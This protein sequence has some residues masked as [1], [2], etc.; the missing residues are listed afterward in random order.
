G[1]DRADADLL[2]ARHTRVGVG[3]R[4]REALLAHHEDGHALLAEGVVDVIR[5]IAAHPGNALGLERAREAV[6]RLDFHR[7]LLGPGVICP[8]SYGAGDIVS[9]R[10]RY[11]CRTNTPPPSVAAYK[12][13]GV[14]GLI[15]SARIAVLVR[16]VL[17]AVQL[18]PASTLLKTPSPVPAK[19]IVGF[20]GS[21]A[22]AWIAMFV[23]PVLAGVQFA[24]PSVLLNTPA[25]GVPT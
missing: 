6:R 1:H 17:I 4:D 9:N 18:P 13:V 8:V 5:G 20:T 12:M 25:A 11:C 19:T 14:T 10:S 24:P 22:S 23:S 21:T 3:D 7:C 2:T 15:A 16:P